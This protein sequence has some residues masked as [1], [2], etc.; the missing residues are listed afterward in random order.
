MKKTIL[1]FLKLSNL[2]KLTIILSLSSLISS[3]FFPSFY[4]DK[5]GNPQAW[6]D[7]SFIFFCG[8]LFPLGGAFIP[9]LF[10]LANP[11]YIIA[12]IF[13]I[14][15][16]P[17]AF[18]LSSTSAVLAIIFSQIDT[19]MTSESGNNSKITSLELGFKLWL[20]SFVILSVGNL[21]TF[22]L[23]SKKEI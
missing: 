12:L 4:I 14:Q 6:A 23:K 17:K 15:R 11:L 7:S 20:T 22:Y 10:W 9:F 2:E 8:A 5:P 19:I 3:L 1:F 16:N 13:T 18:Y 21:I